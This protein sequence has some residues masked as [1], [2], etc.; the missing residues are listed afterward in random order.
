MRNFGL[1]PEN[2]PLH[3][4]RE[5]VSH[6]PQDL[7]ASE[8]ASLRELVRIVR[9]DRTNV[10]KTFPILPEVG[11][12]DG[13]ILISVTAPFRFNS[14]V[15]CVVGGIVAVTHGDVPPASYGPLDEPLVDPSAPYNWLFGSN[16]ITPGS[17][18]FANAQPLALFTGPQEIRFKEREQGQRLTF[19]IHPETNLAL[20][21]SI[22]PD[23]AKVTLVGAVEYLR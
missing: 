9:E 17:S 15:L 23:Y 5:P 12:I 19:W 8:A 14:L 10:E 2:E 13:Q 16:G 4:N 20:R 11:T 21:S 1:P 22:D 18:A 6:N 7:E 3:F